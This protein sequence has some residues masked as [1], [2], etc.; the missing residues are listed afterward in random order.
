M[1][2]THENIVRQLVRLK[3]NPIIDMC[4]IHMIY[5]NQL[6]VCQLQLLGKEKYYF[7]MEDVNKTRTLLISAIKELLFK[8]KTETVD[9]N[10]LMR[11]RFQWKK[12]DKPYKQHQDD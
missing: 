9:E 8:D 4:L 7:S 5:D 6:S 10:V 2:I 11:R 3:E 12:R 1:Y